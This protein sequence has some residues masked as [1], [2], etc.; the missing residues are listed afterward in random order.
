MSLL[1]IGEV[2][3]ILVNNA[4]LQNDTALVNMSLEQWNKVLGYNLTGQFLCTRE[5]AR[6][7]LRRGV[8]LELS[9]SAGKII[10]ITTQG[11]NASS[12]SVNYA[13]VKGGVTLLM[14]SLALELSKEKIRVNGISPGIMKT[15]DKTS[16]WETSKQKAGQLCT[17]ID[18]ARTAVW[19]AS[20]D[21]CHVNGVTFYMDGD[22]VP[23]QD[24]FFEDTP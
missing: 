1:A 8:M 7:F 23:V 21:S 15:P 2:S 4:S 13:A 3:I 10:C 16:E 17:P 5:A 18:I 6:E 19:L 9:R 11:V 20:D 22:T 24:L 12:G 14:E